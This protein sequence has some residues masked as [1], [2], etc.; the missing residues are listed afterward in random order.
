MSE[1]NIEEC[2]NQKQEG[3]T[4]TVYRLAKLGPK[5]VQDM[6]PRIRKFI[7]RLVKHIKKEC[8][9]TLL[10]LGMDISRLMVYV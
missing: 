8:K 9:A 6:R 4:F 3:M 2:V 10:N 7:S 5:M 1:T